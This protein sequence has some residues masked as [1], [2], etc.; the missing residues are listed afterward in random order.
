MI[1]EPKMKPISKPQKEGDRLYNLWW[2]FN[3]CWKCEQFVGWKAEVC[4]YCG[5]ELMEHA[6]N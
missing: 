5:N 6:K 3:H 2:H 4:E 1:D